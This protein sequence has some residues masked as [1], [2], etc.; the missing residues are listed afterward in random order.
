MADVFVMSIRRLGLVACTLGSL[1]SSVDVFF[2]HS[3]SV[4][5][6]MCHLHGPC[7]SCS[8]SVDVAHPRISWSLWNT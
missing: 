8:R 6:P 2:Y 1:E 5:D 3:I 7:C 4:S